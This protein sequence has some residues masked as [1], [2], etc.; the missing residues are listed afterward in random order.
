MISDKHTRLFLKWFGQNYF[1][2][3]LLLPAAA[4]V[5]LYFSSQLI[6]PHLRYEVDVTT[7]PQVERTLLGGLSVQRFPKTILAYTEFK[8]LITILDIIA[9]SVYLLHFAIVAIYFILL[10]VYYRNS[11]S[12][13][14][15]YFMWCFGVMNILATFTHLFWPT[16]PPW[17]NE[18]YGFAP[19]SYTHVKSNP[20]DLKN[21]D[22]L[23]NYPLFQ[24]V[25]AGNAITFGAFPS[26]HAA[27]PML[28]AVFAPT[29]FARTFMACYAGT[30]CWAAVYLNHH[31]LLDVMGA[32]LYVTCSYMLTRRYFKSWRAKMFSTFCQDQEKQQLLEE[33]DDDFTCDPQL[34]KSSL[35]NSTLQ[36]MENEKSQ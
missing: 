26:L 3:A 1:K 24:T 6:P 29:K 12:L 4:W 5:T 23:L 33:I 18:L 31:Y 10:A 28:I 36:I 7:L 19:A 17:Y 35:P 15:F 2:I 32:L 20:A 30:V 16:A 11:K 8:F 9:A 27:W 25:Y 13:V 22:E 34:A 21:I 14:P